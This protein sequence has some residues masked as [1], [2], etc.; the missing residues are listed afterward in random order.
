MACCSGVYRQLRR[1]RT[2]IEGCI[3]MLKRVFGLR[4]RTWKGGA[5]FQQY[6]GLSITSLNLLV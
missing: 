2:G 4:R 1:F 6:V 3:S 5:H